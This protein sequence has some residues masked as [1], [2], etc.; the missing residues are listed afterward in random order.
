MWLEIQ[1]LLNLVSDAGSGQP[2]CP[3]SYHFFISACFYSTLNLLWSLLL[4]ETHLLT[5]PKLKSVSS[6]WP[7]C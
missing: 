5:Q 1:F 4:E 7:A 3:S 6:C 2:G